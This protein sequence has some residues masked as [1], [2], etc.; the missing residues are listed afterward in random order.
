MVQCDQ[1]VFPRKENA[2]VFLFRVDPGYQLLRFRVTGPLFPL[3]KTNL[4]IAIAVQFQEN[5][6]E[7]AVQFPAS[8]PASLLQDT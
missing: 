3:R 7:T 8:V 6:R 4:K 1:S 5:I 2:Q